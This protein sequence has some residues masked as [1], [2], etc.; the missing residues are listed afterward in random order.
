M[1]NILIK[2]QRTRRKVREFSNELNQKGIAEVKKYL[3]NKNM[4]K[5]GS[6]APVDLLKTTYKALHLAGD[7]SN[8]NGDVAVHNYNA[9][10]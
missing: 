1:V 10:T 7:I 9:A 4:L 2:N 6:D 5:I 3:R 8:D